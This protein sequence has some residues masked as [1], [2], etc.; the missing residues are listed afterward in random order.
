[1]GKQDDKKL[2]ALIKKTVAKVEKAPKR[3]TVRAYD[4]TL[5]NRDND[6]DA[7]RERMFKEMK[8]REF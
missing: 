2:A 1:M 7:E 3:K 5:P 6:D 4:E 8:R